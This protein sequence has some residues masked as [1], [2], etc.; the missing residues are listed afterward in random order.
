MMREEPTSP[1]S[2]SLGRRFGAGFNV[3][4]GAVAMLAI[5]LMANYLATRHFKRFAL[6]GEREYKLSPITQQVLRGL[7]NQVKITVYYDPEDALYSHV[8]G[9]LKEYSLRS[10]RLTVDTV[11]YVLEPGKA[12]LV[13]ATYKLPPATKDVVIFDG[14]GGG[15]PKVVRHAELSNYDISDVVAGKSRDVRLK[16]FNGEQ[17]FTSALISLTDRAPQKAYFLAGHGEHDPRETTRDDGYARF[18]L[19]LQENNVTLALL[20]LAGTNEIPADCNLLIIGGPVLLIEPAEREKID[21]YLSSQGGRLLVLFRLLGRPGLEPLLAKWGVDVGDNYVVDLPSSKSADS[22]VVVGNYGAHEIVRPLAQG[23]LPLQLPSPRSIGRRANFP[24]TA[25]APQVQVLASTT[26][27]GEAILDHRNGLRRNAALDTRGV[28]PLMVAV[29][30]GGVRGESR[31]RGAT[32]LVVTGDSHFLDN[33]M[34]EAAA[35]RDFAWNAVNWL[36]DRSSLLGIPPQ[37]VRDF[38]FTMTER[39]MSR[40]RWIVLGAIP[41]AVLFWGWL[42]YVRRQR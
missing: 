25:D 3:L 1:P 7:T 11:N 5:V 10:P 36:L 34:I 21:R 32:R 16:S 42:V 9:L 6:S 30:K 27:S 41:G 39:Q 23:G 24:Q 4:V 37:P 20:S 19:L 31:G 17:H 12:E 26:E 29:E 2:Y 14:G 28:I 18:A 38:K 35:N 40:V 15:A 22:Y 8:T 13:K 33:Q